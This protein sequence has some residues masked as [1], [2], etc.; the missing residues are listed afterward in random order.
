[1]G[2]PG[3]AIASFLW[4]FVR[5]TITVTLRFLESADS[6]DPHVPEQVYRQEGCRLDRSGGF[7]L[8]DRLGQAGRNGHNASSLSG[9]NGATAAH[10]LSIRDAGYLDVGPEH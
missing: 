2:G 6:F 5:V 9:R 4:V 10:G 7:F 1:M 8:S 3:L